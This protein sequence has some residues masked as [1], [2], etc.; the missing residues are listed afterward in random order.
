ML[1][2]WTR[3][4]DRS[5]PVSRAFSTDL[6]IARE[7]DDRSVVLRSALGVNCVRATIGPVLQLLI[8]STTRKKR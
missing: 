7:L 4:D 5:H 1:A 6:G 3:L 8:G 2:V